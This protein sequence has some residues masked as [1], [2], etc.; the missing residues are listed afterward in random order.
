MVRRKRRC[1]VDFGALL[2]AA[3]RGGDTLPAERLGGEL[4][5]AMSLS[6]SAIRSAVPAQ[7]QASIF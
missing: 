5:A 6:M 3:I 4:P 2:Q 1:A 7:S